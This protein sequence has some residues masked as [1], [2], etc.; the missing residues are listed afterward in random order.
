MSPTTISTHKQARC[1]LEG[2]GRHRIIQSHGGTPDVLEFFP[3]MS[4]REIFLRLRLFLRST[5]ANV[6]VVSG[7]A[8]LGIVRVG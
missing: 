7:G 6:G 5:D 2:Y 1:G 8:R 4:A 3:V